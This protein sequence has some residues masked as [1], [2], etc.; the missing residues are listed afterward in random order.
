MASIHHSENSNGENFFDPS[1]ADSG[2]VET[3][4]GVQHITSAEGGLPAT[5]GPVESGAGPSLQ[6]GNLQDQIEARFSEKDWHQDASYSPVA[7]EV[8]ESSMGAQEHAEY[9]AVPPQR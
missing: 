9:R 7:S 3:P 6:V 1:A 4:S 5:D 2:N 8:P